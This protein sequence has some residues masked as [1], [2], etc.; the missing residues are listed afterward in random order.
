MIKCWKINNFNYIKKVVNNILGDKDRI[1][2]NE[3]IKELQILHSNIKKSKYR[4]KFHIQP[5]TGLLN[6]PN[7]FCYFENKWYLF[8]QWFPFD[9]IHGVKNWYLTVSDDLVHWKNKGLSLKPDKIFDNKGVYSGT[10]IIENGKLNI[11]FTG[12]HRDENNIRKPYQCIAEL[13]NGKFVKKPPIIEMDSNYTEHQRDPKIIKI[14]DKYFIIIGAQNKNKKARLLLYSSK[15]LYSDWKLLGEIKINGYEDFGYMWECPDLIKIR[16]KYILAFSPQGLKQEGNKY[17]NIYQSGYFIGTMDFNNLEFFPDTEFEEF[18]Y[19]FDFYAV[20]T[21]NQD[22]Y[23]D[24]SIM[25]AWMGL[26]DLKYTTDKEKWSGCL[27]IP[28]ELKIVNSKLIQSPIEQ[29]YLLR[30]KKIYSSITKRYSLKD[31]NQT[32]IILNNISSSNFKMNIC[33]NQDKSDSG[34]EIKYDKINR[35]FSIDKSLLYNKSNADYGL[36]RFINLDNLEKL[37]IFIDSS[38]IEIF[39]NDGQYTM[40]SRIFPDANENMLYF[41]SDMYIDIELWKLGNGVEDEF[42]I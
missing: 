4:Q 36:T 22:R 27:S 15:N 8:Y 7:G 23:N 9:S 3:D 1:I 29:I 12:N 14:D 40:T 31:I 13:K 34:F 5:V 11:V 20:Q 28:R 19:G 25:I 24:K 33:A 2:S 21:A 38:S 18:D 26:P 10:S 17:N 6:D 32:E 30:K 42:I 37:D 35:K 41:N 39:I 16:D